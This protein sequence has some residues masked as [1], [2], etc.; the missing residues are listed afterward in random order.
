MRKLLEVCARL[1]ARRAVVLAELHPTLDAT[2]RAALAELGGRF[3]PWEG[4]RDAAGQA[5]AL[6]EGRSRASFGNSPHNFR[7]ALAVDVVLDPRKVAVRPHKQDVEVPDLWDDES[8][9]ALAAWE[10]LERAAEKYGLERVNIEV[11]GVLRRDR[12]HLQLAGWR[13][14]VPH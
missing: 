2:V 8:A 4:Y 3:T 11:N 10:A 14:L 7:P 9:E 13:S 5:K 12:P 1:D 6:A